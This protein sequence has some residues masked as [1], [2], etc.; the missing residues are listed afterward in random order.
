MYK[1]YGLCTYIHISL[2]CMGCRPEINVRDTAFKRGTAYLE[3]YCL[4]IAFTSFLERTKGSDITFQASQRILM[5]LASHVLML[6]PGWR[7]AVDICQSCSCIIG[8]CRASVIQSASSRVS[9]CWQHWPNC[10]SV[11]SYCQGN[12]ILSASASLFTCHCHL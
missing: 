2:F 4:L 10:S 5:L 12:V 9:S 6:L 7:H 8:I 3:R 11:N 1:Q